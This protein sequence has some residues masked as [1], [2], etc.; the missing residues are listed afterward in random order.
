[1]FNLA[2]LHSYCSGRQSCATHVLVDKLLDVFGRLLIDW[3]YYLA[4]EL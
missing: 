2:Q 1:M 4:G 3:G